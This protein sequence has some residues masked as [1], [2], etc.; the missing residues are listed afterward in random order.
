MRQGKASVP[1]TSNKNPKRNI[2]I[3]PLISTTFCSSEEK[4]PSIRD[5]TQWYHSFTVLRT[6]LVCLWCLRHVLKGS[7]TSCYDAMILHKFTLVLCSNP[8]STNHKD[9]SWPAEYQHWYLYSIYYGL[10]ASLSSRKHHTQQHKLVKIQ[11]YTYF[12]RWLVHTGK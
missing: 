3:C 12:L 9:S 6:S 4:G 2:C 5:L 8:M 7:S 11:S 1:V 10:E